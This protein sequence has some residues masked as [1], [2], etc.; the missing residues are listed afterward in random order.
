MELGLKG[1]IALVAASSQGLGRAVAETL[2]AEGASV[3]VCA[4]DAERLKKTAKEISSAT[5]SDV[6]AV[7]ADLSRSVDIANLVRSAVK[8]FG[9]VHILVNNAGGPPV[10][11]FDRLSDEQW[12]NGVHL[13]MMSA[14]R[15]MRSVLP[16]MRDQKWGR[17]ITINSLV[18]KQPIDDLVV[19]STLR[20]GLIGLSK[21]LSNQYAKDNILINTVCPGFILTNRQK[22]ISAARAAKASISFEEYIGSQAKDI[23]LGRLGEPNEIASV[24]AFLASEK[25][26]YITGATISVDGGVMKGLL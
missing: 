12:E 14:I 15:L 24:V 20:P 21:V 11:P 9:T 23:P 19:S 4:R 18:A 5:G 17:I 13:T 10:D 6:F 7:P 3:V 22:E 2:A 25:A 16:L 1:K 26:S 8:K